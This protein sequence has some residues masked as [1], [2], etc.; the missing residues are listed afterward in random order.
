QT[1]ILLGDGGDTVRLLDPSGKVYDA[2]T[3]ALAKVEDQSVC[4]LPDGNGS[5]YEDCTPTPNQTN[6]R[7]GTVPSMPAGSGFESP[8][9]GLPDTLP[10]P[11][12]FAECRGYGANIW[13]SYYWD[14]TGWKGGDQYV[15]DDASKWPSFVE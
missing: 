1:N 8:V 4:R 14:K 12:L 10:Q 15:P 9:C 5:W 11:F 7:G 6:A 2:Y 3:Y 13:N